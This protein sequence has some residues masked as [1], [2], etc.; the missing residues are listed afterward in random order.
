M[1]RVGEMELELQAQLLRRGRLS[2]A[3]VVLSTTCEMLY[4]SPKETCRE[5]PKTLAGNRSSQ[6]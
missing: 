4:Y 2:G 6:F 3:G 1:S 5:P